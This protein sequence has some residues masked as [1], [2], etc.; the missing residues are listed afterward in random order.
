MVAGLKLGIILWF[1]RCIAIGGHWFLMWRSENWNGIEAAFRF[2][3][4]QFP[5]LLSTVA[6]DRDWRAADV[7]AGLGGAKSAGRLR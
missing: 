5:T 1:N 2:S 6:G 7:V 3:A 4:S